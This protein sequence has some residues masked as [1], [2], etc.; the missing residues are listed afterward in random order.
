[1]RHLTRTSAFV[2]AMVLTAVTAQA[3]GAA[4]ATGRAAGQE[5][6]AAAQERRAEAR[7]TLGQKL[8]DM[9]PEERKAALAQAKERREERRDD[10]RE[11]ATPEQRAWAQAMATEGKRIQEGVKAGALTRETAAAQLKTWRDANPRPKGNGGL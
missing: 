11:H 6:R 9:N 3:Q 4:G 7:E 10:R 8:K 2:A 1:M 5:R